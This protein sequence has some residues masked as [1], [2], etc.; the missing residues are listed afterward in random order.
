MAK[1]FKMDLRVWNSEIICC[2]FYSIENQ[3]VQF[4]VD[5]NPQNVD[6]AKVAEVLEEDI[7]LK[8]RLTDTLGVD[9]ANVAASHRVRIQWFSQLFYMIRSLKNEKGTH[10]WSFL[11]VFLQLILLLF[12]SFWLLNLSTIE[13]IEFDS[14]YNSEMKFSFSR[15]VTKKLFLRT[16]GRSHLMASFTWWNEAIIE[17]STLWT[18]M[19]PVQQIAHNPP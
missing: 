6:A 3:H 12:D 9:V 14:M 11:L 15:K 10:N 2:S 1:V 4:K 5:A 13:L 18:E 8:K 19:N 7:N 17:V 16:V